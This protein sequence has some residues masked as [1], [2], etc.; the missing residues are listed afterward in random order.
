MLRRVIDTDWNN[1]NVVRAG[2]IPFIIKN[3]V[4]FYAFGIANEVGDL[5]DFGGHREDFDNDL[6]D[7]A[8]REYKE[9]CFEIFGKIDRNSLSDCYVLEGQDTLEILLEVTGDL[10]EY[11]YKFREMIG[12]NEQLELQNIVWLT[13]NQIILNTKYV[14]NVD[15]IFMYDKI[16]SSFGISLPKNNIIDQSS[17]NAKRIRTKYLIYITYYNDYLLKHGNVKYNDIL[18]PIFKEIV[19]MGFFKYI[20]F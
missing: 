10:Y 19:R 6:L 7:T 16:Q 1:S 17:P 4:K 18:D 2:I 5:C 13:Y 9:E 8:I 20:I 14:D 11:T 15:I 12:N 3:G